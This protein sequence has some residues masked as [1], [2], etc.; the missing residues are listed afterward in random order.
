MFRLQE[1]SD[2][3]NS[4][5]SFFPSYESIILFLDYYDCKLFQCMVLHI[6]DLLAQADTF[7]MFTQQDIRQ[8]RILFHVR[9]SVVNNDHHE[10]RHPRHGKSVDER[11]ES[12]PTLGKNR[13]LLPKIGQ[14][15]VKRIII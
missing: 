2:L 9:D 13:S 10:G 11:Q 5:T 1:K 14:K 15:L 7:K 4:T 12:F 6:Y 8:R 3:K